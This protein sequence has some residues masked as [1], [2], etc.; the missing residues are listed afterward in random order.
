MK[1]EHYIFGL[2]GVGAVIV[3]YILFKEMASSQAASDSGTIPVPEGV[4]AAQT[5][6]APQPINL[7]NITIGETPP[8]Q[9]YNL[10]VNDYALPTVQTGSPQSDCGCDD[11][12]C[13][14]V[15]TCQT[16]Q[17]VPDNVLEDM[18][19]NVQSFQQKVAG[20]TNSGV[21]AARVQFTAA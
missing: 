8:T 17:Q 12:D 10:P 14:E 21:E 7:G 16:V 5:Y 20:K 2:I 1:K 4:S 6:P 3:L 19:S 11:N 18:V 9:S 13:D 15:G